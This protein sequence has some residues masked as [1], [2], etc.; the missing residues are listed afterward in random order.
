MNKLESKGTLAIKINNS[1]NTYTIKSLFSYLCGNKYNY[2]RKCIFTPLR[3]LNQHKIDL[4]IM[5]KCCLECPKPKEDGIWFLTPPSSFP[6]SGLFF[7]EDDD[8]KNI[9]TETRIIV[10]FCVWCSLTDTCRNKNTLKEFFKS[11]K[12][13]TINRSMQSDVMFDMDELGF[14]WKTFL[15]ID[16]EANKF[17]NYGSTNNNI[18]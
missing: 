2:C 10:D 16:D 4:D 13:G 17:E 18:L 8:Y 5:D 9:C 3:Q 1:I 11:Y 12:N 6:K 14:L 15:L 7:Q